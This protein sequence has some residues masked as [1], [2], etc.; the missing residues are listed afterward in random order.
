MSITPSR[1]VSAVIFFS[2]LASMIIFFHGTIYHE[3][4]KH[5]HQLQTTEG[6]E[7]QHLVATEEERQKQLQDEF[8]RQMNIAHQHGR[9]SDPHSA[10]NA[11]PASKR[12]PPGPS[13][14]NGADPDHSAPVEFPSHLPPTM[15]S[16]EHAGSIDIVI[17]ET[18]GFHD[19]VSA[20]LVH[21]FGS[22]SNA[23]LHL[24]LERPRYGLLDV[25]KSF[26][27]SS[28]IV[29]V[30]STSEFGARGPKPQILVS[31]TCEV[32]PLRL[33][34]QFKSLLEE[35]KTFLYCVVHHADRWH[36]SENDVALQPWVREGLV[37]FIALSEHTANYFREHA[38]SEPTLRA[39]TVLKVLPPV[40]PLVFPHKA[41]A[42]SDSRLE[43]VVQGSYE[44]TRR[45]YQGVF[46]TLSD[47]LG[48]RD[49]N[50]HLDRNLT[51]H[52]VGHGE[53]P[54]IPEQ[55]NEHV[56][57]DEKLNYIP[58]YSLI[59][60]S[61]A[62]LPAFAGSEYL[63]RQASSSIAASLIGG[64]P[65]VVDRAML[66]A[67]SYLDEGA[68]WVREEGESEMDVVTKLLA[69]TPEL[70]E[71][72]K[73]LVRIQCRQIVAKNI[74]SVSRWVEV[75]LRRLSV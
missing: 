50:R 26:N 53:H 45:D 48:Q 13:P 20:A 17:V 75:A 40:F 58:F 11:G 55:L 47:L 72:Q 7:H 71:R 18:T 33:D 61:A 41:K 73:H 32:D 31:T 8:D 34:A 69:S 44:T 54:T 29:A 39:S 4:Y 74:K 16:H 38:V 14:Q 10:P 62:L 70:I 15:V 28:P 12:P 6:H 24:Y 36:G 2:F 42:L 49:D 5:T 65:V 46:S 30:N 60:D 23:R 1:R 67:Y 59:S 56:F 57:F 25:L 51:L 3:L 43:I 52:L 27:L 66:D 19:E 37:D 68:V 64:T 35:R 63:D 22:L 21:A 9:P